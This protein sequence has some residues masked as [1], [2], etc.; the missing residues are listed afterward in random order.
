MLPLVWLFGTIKPLISQRYV[1]LMLVFGTIT[2]SIELILASKSPCPPFVNTMKGNVFVLIIWLSTFILLGYSR[3]VIANYIRNCNS[4]NGMLWFG[5][6]VQLDALI[7]SIIVYLMV[8]TF[9][10]F[11]EQ[12]PCEQVQC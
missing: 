2:F 9:S 5:T 8:N 6:N 12:L 3:L 10:L 4:S 1:L 7:G 11:K